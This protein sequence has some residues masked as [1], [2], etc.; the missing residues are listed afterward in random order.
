MRRRI[1]ARKSFF[2]LPAQRADWKAG[3][4]TYRDDS[5]RCL[6]R[7]ESLDL[8]DNPV[9]YRGLSSGTSLPKNVDFIKKSTFFVVFKRLLANLGSA[10]T[11]VSEQLY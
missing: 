9:G 3:I 8:F 10:E 6:R 2:S 7:G 4:H 5:P 11:E 1:A